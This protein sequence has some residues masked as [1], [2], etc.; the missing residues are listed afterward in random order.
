VSVRHFV[1]VAFRRLMRIYFREIEVVA[2][3]PPDTRGRLFG[4]N[5]VNGLVDPI[6]VMTSSP[7]D[8]A[9]VAKSTLWN[10]PGLNLL[11]NVAEAVPVVRKR[12]DPTRPSSANDEVFDKVAAHLGR[13]GNILIFPEGTS[14][15]EPHVLG[16]KTGAGRMLARAH[17]KG[18]RGLTFQAV[19]L[20]FDE[21]DVFRSRALVLYGPVRE[22]DDAADAGPDLANAITETMRADL[23]ELVVEGATA[24]ERTLIARVAQMIAH[25]AG[26]R[27]LAAWNTIG[28]QVEAA[29]AALRDE[30]LYRDLD[31]EVSRYFSLLTEAGLADADLLAGAS[32]RHFMGTLALVALAPLAVLGCVLYWVPYQV[33]RLA[34]SL[35]KGET[36]VVSTYKLGM[37]VLA[38]PLWAM[39]L[40]TAALL[41]FPSPVH[42]A[43]A[44]LVLLA[45]FA[46][47]PFLDRMDRYRGRLRLG[48]KGVT[49]SQLL[50]A[51]HDASMMIRRAR[52]VVERAGGVQGDAASVELM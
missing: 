39:V 19:A 15:N 6:L 41:A 18:A 11:L 1:L 25:D 48:A 38:F 35:A 22:V 20:E 26:D 37:G 50:A 9:P 33:P 23:T 31:A 44:L 43:V 27:S 5:H 49:R 42:L 16:L 40:V 13:G 34:P 46:A 12:D 21:R 45:P 4:A 51:R 28:R 29:R 52:E 3:P 24:A 47:L 30:E 2:P 14:H 7:C 32:P 10:V 36:D 8:I 17:E